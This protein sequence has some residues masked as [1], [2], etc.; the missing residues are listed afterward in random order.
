MRHWPRPGGLAIRCINTLLTRLLLGAHQTLDAKKS[1]PVSLPSIW[2]MQRDDDYYLHADSRPPPPVKGLALHGYTASNGYPIEN[3]ILSLPGN[4]RC[5]DG[6]KLP[7]PRAL[8]ANAPSGTDSEFWFYR[9]GNEGLYVSRTWLFGVS[10]GC[11]ATVK[12]VTEVINLSIFKGR[13]RFIT[14]ETDEAPRPSTEA[15]AE[16]AGYPIPA[17]FVD[18]ND[19]ELRSYRQ[20]HEKSQTVDRSLKTGRREACFDTSAAFALSSR[21]FLIEAGPWQ[22]MTTYSDSQD[23]DGSNLSETGLFELDPNAWI[24]GRLFEWGRKI[25]LSTPPSTSA[26]TR[27]ATGAGKAR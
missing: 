15:I 1:D 4:A 11:N 10:E 17:A 18:I 7:D 8:P 22:G 25:T 2:Q 13:A 12:V 21:C 23:D 24:D 26:D 3:G 16:Q 6:V 27:V 20:H 5:K 19:R 14:K 9:S